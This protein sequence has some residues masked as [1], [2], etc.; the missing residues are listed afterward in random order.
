MAD[1]NQGNGQEHETLSRCEGQKLAEAFRDGDRADPFLK[2]PPALLSAK[3]IKEYV[4]H[5]GAIAPQQFPPV[6][7]P[8]VSGVFQGY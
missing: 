5:T 8:L 4:L 7:P 2:T 6:L 1:T 3:H